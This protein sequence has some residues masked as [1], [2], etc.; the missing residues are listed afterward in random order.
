M[1]AYHKIRLTCYGHMMKLAKMLGSDFLEYKTDCIYFYYS[2]ENIL[3][4]HQFMQK[5]GLSY[6]FSDNVPEGII[7]E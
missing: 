5:K 4:I 7:E 3:A 2:E 1:K 6:K